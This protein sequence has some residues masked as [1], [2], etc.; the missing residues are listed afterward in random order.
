M[1]SKSFSNVLTTITKTVTRTSDFFAY[2]KTSFIRYS[3]CLHYVMSAVFPPQSHKS[4]RPPYTEVQLEVHLQRC[5]SETASFPR[6]PKKKLIWYNKA[7]SEMQ[8]QDK[9][10][11]LK[12]KS[13]TLTTFSTTSRLLRLEKMNAEHEHDEEE[14]QEREVEEQLVDVHRHSKQI[15]G[16]H[17]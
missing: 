17:V 12:Q 2:F 8:S 15:Q 4:R 11:V 14:C 16:G 10:Y 7:F 1:F 6:L 3:N 13:C 5:A 9:S